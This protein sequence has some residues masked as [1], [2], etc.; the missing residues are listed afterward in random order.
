M[1]KYSFTPKHVGMVLVFA[2]VLF[3][4]YFVST[5]MSSNA[6]NKSNAAVRM[7]KRNSGNKDNMKN[8]VAGAGA[9]FKGNCSD[10]AAP[11][12]VGASMPYAAQN[13]G[14]L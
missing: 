14:G 2:L 10:C 6:K 4:L 8:L 3:G 7:N 9:D 5:S 13:W 12:R 11:A 1:P